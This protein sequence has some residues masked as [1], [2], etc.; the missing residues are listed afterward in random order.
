MA[1]SGGSI[2][3][4]RRVS[5]ATGRNFFVK[6]LSAAPAAMFE[7][8]AAG[9]DIIRRTGSLRVPEVFGYTPHWLLLEYLG[10][11]ALQPDYWR[12]L[13]TGLARMHQASTTGFGLAF[14]NYCGATPQPNSMLPDGHQFFA[15]RRLLYQGRMALDSGLLEYEVLCQLERLCARLPDLVPE[16]PASLLH[17]DLWHGNLHADSRGAPVLIDPAC[18]YGWAET[19]IAMTQ[20]FGGFA[21]EFYT[22]YQ[23]QSPLQPGWKQRLGIYNLYHL[24]NHLNLF[25]HSYHQQVI[26]VL[27]SYV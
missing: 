13:G 4:S 12:L 5:T 7:A 18:Y 11:G 19:D 23:A 9:L 27:K 26:Q 1:V 2:C 8:E 21:A 14:D 17:G 20:L 6:T 15:E 3:E 10:P 16:Q 25:G 22:A 24:L